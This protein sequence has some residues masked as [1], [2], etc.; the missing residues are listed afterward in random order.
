MAL[1]LRPLL[2]DSS[3]KS[4]YGSQTLAVASLPLSG[5]VDTSLAGFESGGAESCGGV[6]AAVGA[7]GV[8]DVANSAPKSGDTS[9]AGFAAGRRLPQ[10]PGGRTAMPAALRYAL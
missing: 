1:A 9:L 7:A 6:G 5:S 2:N 10:P 3:M 8:A 4:R